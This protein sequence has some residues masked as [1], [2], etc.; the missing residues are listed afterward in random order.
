MPEYASRPKY[1]KILNVVG[2]SICKRYRT[3]RIY[4]NM[5]WQSSKYIL[6]SKN[7]TF[8]I[9][10]ELH[11]VLNMPQYGWIYLIRT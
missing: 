1:G 5:L 9:L 3:L 11:S 10:Q 8:L 4:Q 6:Y 2:F 7:A